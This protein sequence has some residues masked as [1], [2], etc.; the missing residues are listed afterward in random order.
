MH[1]HEIV[2]FFL[3]EHRFPGRK[4]SIEQCLEG[5]FPHNERTR[6]THG[7][8]CRECGLWFNKGDI[9]YEIF[10]G[11]YNPD[12]VWM[13]LNNRLIDIS[14]KFSSTNERHNVDL[15]PAR[16]RVINRMYK[17][18]MDYLDR[19]KWNGVQYC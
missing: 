4:K 1:D 2:P 12:H 6:W 17:R 5:E 8:E 11:R 19:L 7:F 16:M 3:K 15:E 10:E 18:R 14:E 13:A 9:G